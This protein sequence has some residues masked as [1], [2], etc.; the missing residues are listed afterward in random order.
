MKCNCPYHALAR[1]LKRRK[2]TNLD[3]V[4]DEAKIRAR[5]Q[6]AGQRPGEPFF[7]RL[8]PGGLI[9]LGRVGAAG[10][11]L[12]QPQPAGNVM[13]PE[14]EVFL[15]LGHIGVPLERDGAGRPA[16]G[17]HEVPPEQQQQQP[18]IRDTPFRQRMRELFAGIQL[19]AHEAP[20]PN[21]E[22]QV[23]HMQALFEHIP[24]APPI[25]DHMDVVP[26]PAHDP[27]DIEF[28][29]DDDV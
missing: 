11:I 24:P 22:E 25:P 26:P 20:A 28:P 27:M 18:R 12:A 21:G 17:F 29:P 15:P 2:F 5:H 9:P 7:A 1:E 4:P 8:Q 16:V 3:I 13:V 6:A 10:P 23:R 14:R 19:P